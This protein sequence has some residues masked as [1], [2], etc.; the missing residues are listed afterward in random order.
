MS[1]APLAQNRIWQDYMMK[2]VNRQNV[3]G[4]KNGKLAKGAG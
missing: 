3:I 1:P 2:Q 4:K